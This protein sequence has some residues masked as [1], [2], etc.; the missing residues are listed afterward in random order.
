MK[1]RAARDD[2]QAY[3]KQIWNSK[4]ERGRTEKG[5]KKKKRKKQM[6]TIEEKRAEEMSGNLAAGAEVCLGLNG[7]YNLKEDGRSARRACVRTG[8]W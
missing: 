8:K 3:R 7:Y 5:K 2:P 1:A 6:K 4:K